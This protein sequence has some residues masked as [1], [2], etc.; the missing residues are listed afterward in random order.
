MDEISSGDCTGIGISSK[1]HYLQPS[2]THKF[3]LLATILDTDVRPPSPVE[4][5]EG[6]VLDVGLH[7]G[8][9]EFAADETFCVGDPNIYEME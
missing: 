9:I 5:L 8:I 6:E 7:L 3:L 4:N 1:G 2:L